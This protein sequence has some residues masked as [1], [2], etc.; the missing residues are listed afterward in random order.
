MNGGLELGLLDT[1]SLARFTAV[2][3]G[4]NQGQGVEAGADIVGIGAVRGQ[5][6][7]VRP[8]ADLGKPAQI[9]GVHP[10]AGVAGMGSS[11]ALHAGAEVNNIRPYLFDIVITQ[12]QFLHRPR[13]KRFGDDVRPFDELPG[14]L[15]PARVLQ[16]DSDAVFVG[17]M[18]AEEHA[19]VGCRHIIGKRAASSGGVQPFVGL[20]F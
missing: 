12:T 3:E 6:T 2:V 9:D 20:E 11:S 15:F 7:P 5:G 17:I 19:A 4:G 16:V 13:R 1:W 18:A 14:E 10:V 8:A